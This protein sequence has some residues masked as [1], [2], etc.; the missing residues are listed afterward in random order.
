MRLITKRTVILFFV[1]IVGL[2]AYLGY[3]VSRLD[4]PY[5]LQNCPAVDWNMSIHSATFFSYA[6]LHPFSN[7]SPDAVAICQRLS[8]DSLRP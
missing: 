6:Y 7:L 8:M 1:L 3:T 4:M 2:L 5:H